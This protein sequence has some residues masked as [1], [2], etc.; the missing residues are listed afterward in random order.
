MVQKAAQIKK[1]TA[2]ER[3]EGPA[4]AF[5]WFGVQHLAMADCGG[6]STTLGL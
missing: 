5:S 3:S 4:V 2:S 1:V 6:F